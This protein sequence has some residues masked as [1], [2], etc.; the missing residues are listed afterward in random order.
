MTYQRTSTRRTPKH[1]AMHLWL[2]RNIK[3]VYQAI[4]LSLGCEKPHGLVTAVEWQGERP[5]K[6]TKSSRP[7]YPDCQRESYCPKYPDGR[8]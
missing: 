1:D 5:L 7:V 4:Y 8:C 3:S 2:T 6:R